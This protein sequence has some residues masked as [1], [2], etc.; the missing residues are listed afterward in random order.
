M[1]RGKKPTSTGNRNGVGT[2]GLEMFREA[3]KK[4]RVGKHIYRR[5]QRKKV[6]NTKKQKPT[7]EVWG[8]KKIGKKL[9]DPR[10]T[11]GVG[12]RKTAARREK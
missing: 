2:P 4:K 9:E 5:K 12:N 8:W 3:K 7:G 6:K 11:L 1:N 10:E